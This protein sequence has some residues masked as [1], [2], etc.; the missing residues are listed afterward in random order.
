MVNDVLNDSEG[1]IDKIT[2]E[3]D[4]SEEEV[5]DKINEKIEEY[6]GLL[7]E[8]G[9]AYSIAKEMGIEEGK[10]ERSSGDQVKIKSLEEGQ[11]NVNLEARVKRVYSTN[12]FTR[13][14]GEGNVTNV[15]IK[16]DTGESIAVLW[17]KKPLLDKIDRNTPIRISNGYVK[18]RNDELRVNVGSYGT[19]E[20]L[21]D[22]EIPEVSEERV[23][24]NEL[25][26]DMDNVNLYARVE[27]VFPM[28]TFQKEDRE[29][30]VTNSL[31]SDENGRT[32][33]VMWGDHAE[34][35]QEMNKNSLIKVEGGYTKEND[36]QI[37]LHLG[38]RGRLKINPET[39]V[40]VSEV[41]T[42]RAKIKE[43]KEEDNPGEKLIRATIVQAYEPTI[44]DICPEC[45]EMIR[46][47]ECREHGEVEEPK[48]VPILNLMLDDGEDTI[49]STLYR[50]KAESIM[51]TTGEELK[52][53]DKFQEIKRNLLGEEKVFTGKVKYNEDFNRYDF[54]ITSVQDLDINKEIERIKGENNV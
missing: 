53:G 14:D 19:V 7:T 34:E 46:E 25:E 11:S 4:L 49:R 45:G 16:D 9:A 30:K 52:Q 43:L 48:H 17:N 32:R 20:V 10:P 12:T 27:R 54:T 47:G 33:L 42:E 2:E 23:G 28:N 5:M 37:E 51:E 18:E 8:A 36:G 6:G 41:K 29:G 44:L 21:D 40:D 39:D 35:A 15:E 50:E 13:D 22:S 3:S 26:S 1:I 31:I 24:I 38:W